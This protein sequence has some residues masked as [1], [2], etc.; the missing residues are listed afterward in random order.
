MARSALALPTHPSANSARQVPSRHRSGRRARVKV[1]GN[2]KTASA[3][4][5]T[6]FAMSFTAAGHRRA[7]AFRF[8]DR[9]PICRNDAIELDEDVT[10]LDHVALRSLWSRIDVPPAW[11]NSDA[12]R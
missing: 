4:R 10:R 11:A 7:A 1:A 3:T 2:P 5:R 9:R 6:S 8:R 12:A